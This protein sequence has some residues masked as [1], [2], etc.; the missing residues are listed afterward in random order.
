MLRS[1]T[2]GHADRVRQLIATTPAAAVAPALDTTIHAGPEQV[3]VAPRG[4]LDLGTAPILDADLRAIRDLGFTTI[5][6]DLRGLS[7]IDSAGV[8]LLLEWATSGARRGH[9]FRLIP[10]ADR[11]QLVFRLTGVLEALGLEAH[12][13]AA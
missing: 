7:F 6:V 3:I 5:V 10:G 12:R 8:N 13:R 9:A 2:P 4:E 11:V 1:T